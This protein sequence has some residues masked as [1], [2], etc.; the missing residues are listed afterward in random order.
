MVEHSYTYSCSTGVK[1]VPRILLAVTLGK[2]FCYS[3]GSVDIV[4]CIG[5][6]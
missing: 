4:G 5:G 1:P 6:V 3:V 2:T